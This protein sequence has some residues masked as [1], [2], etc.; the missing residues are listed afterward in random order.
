[1]CVSFHQV[2]NH[3]RVKAIVE[4]L[5]ACPGMQT[6]LGRKAKQRLVAAAAAAAAAMPEPPEGVDAEWLPDH[7]VKA[8]KSAAKQVST[9]VEIR[10]ALDLGRGAKQRLVAAGAAILEPSED[11]R[12]PD[13]VV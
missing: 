10:W 12:L 3:H 4:R 2:R 9:G 7:V 13:H 1:M 5:F 8:A 11:V 6:E